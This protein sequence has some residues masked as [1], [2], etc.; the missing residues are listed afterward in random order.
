M[1]CFESVCVEHC[2]LFTQ[3]SLRIP[4]R[5]NVACPSGLVFEPCQTRKSVV[6]H[7]LVDPNLN[8]VS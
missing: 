6:D 7:N 8:C 5:T 2:K 4:N 1:S 3:A